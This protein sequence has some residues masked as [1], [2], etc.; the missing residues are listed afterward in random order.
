MKRADMDP[1]AVAQTIHYSAAMRS[2]C[3]TD[4]NLWM[5][6]ADAGAA[7]RGHVASSLTDKIT[8][9]IRTTEDVDHDYDTA[10]AN[11]TT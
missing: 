6:I 7:R 8:D 1:T 11:Q 3:L 5:R 10:A 9:D 4:R 2:D